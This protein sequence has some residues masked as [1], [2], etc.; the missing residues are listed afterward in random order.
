[1]D[2]LSQKRM[3]TTNCETGF[4]TDY[5]FQHPVDPLS[6]EVS[7][8]L[9]WS[10]CGLIVIIRVSTALSKCYRFYRSTQQTEEVKKSSNVCCRSF[11]ANISA[12]ERA[13]N[14]SRALLL[15][16]SSASAVIYILMMCLVG[17]N[18]SSVDNGA[19]LAL[20]TLSYLCFGI[21]YNITLFRIV[22]LGEKTIPI[23]SILE[24]NR[25]LSQFTILLKFLV[26]V[27]IILIVIGGVSGTIVILVFPHQ[28]KPLSATTFGTFSV[29]HLIATITIIYQHQRCVAHLQALVK[30]DKTTSNKKNMGAVIN[31]G[32]HSGNSNNRKI[33]LA[34]YFLRRRQFAIFVFGSA[35][36]LILL[37][38]V[39]LE[40][41]TWAFVI[42]GLA[43]PEAMINFFFEFRLR[44]KKSANR[45]QIAERVIS[46][47]DEAKTVAGNTYSMSSKS[48]RVGPVRK[49]KKRLKFLMSIINEEPSHLAVSQ[50][51]S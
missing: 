48:Y 25:R 30:D 13:R 7:L 21:D 20:F 12:S 41:W 15:F 49:K 18:I 45:T 50:T 47:Q 38:L 16:T 36:F 24:T 27:Q 17:E 4:A 31:A 26:I 10:V 8:P 37:L 46:L 9:F 6:C 43:L 35:C 34:I 22:R 11:G 5:T 19:P 28:Y 1:M 2:E 14:R 44:T 23:K 51:A 40:K 42:V 32:N 39:L 29:F 33:L 3:N